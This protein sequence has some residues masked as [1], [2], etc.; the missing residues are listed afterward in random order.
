MAG[1]YKIDGPTV[2]IH[3]WVNG[4]LA[5]QEFTIEGR[6]DHVVTDSGNWYDVISTNMAAATSFVRMTKY[7]N[8]PKAGLHGMEIVSRLL[9]D[10]THDEFYYGKVGG[11]GYILHESEIEIGDWDD[12][13]EAD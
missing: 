13:Y 9:S 8:D 2:K 5:G 6:A 10:H 3:D 7:T 4:G 11:Y 1:I 12:G